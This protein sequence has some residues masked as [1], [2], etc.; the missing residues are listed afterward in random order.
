MNPGKDLPMKYFGSRFVSLVVLA[1]SSIGYADEPES[2]A[3]FAPPRRIM[4]G[5]VFAGQG[6]MFPSPVMHDVDGDKRLDL[7]VAD[8]RGT[9]TVARRAPTKA[10][11]RFERETPMLG[12]GRKPLKFNNW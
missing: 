11:V 5:R 3:R 4:A 6:R 10:P 9:V 7:V 2:E 1:G 8:L 12:R